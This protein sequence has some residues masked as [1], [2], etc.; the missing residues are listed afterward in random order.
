MVCVL[1]SVAAI[2]LMVDPSPTNYVHEEIYL[3]DNK[4]HIRYSVN[5]P[6]TTFILP[7]ELSEVSGLSLGPQKNQLLAVQDEDGILYSINLN[8]GDII[9]RTRFAGKGDYEAVENAAGFQYI[10]KSNGNLYRYKDQSHNEKI[11][12]IPKDYVKVNLEGMAYDNK[13]E[14]LIFACKSCSKE[15]KK[16]L[17][18][19]F[20]SL[21]L[22]KVDKKAKLLFQVDL[23]MVQKFII[24]NRTDQDIR[25]FDNVYLRN[26][27]KFKFAPSAISIHPKSGD[28]YVLSSVGKVLMVLNSQGNIKQLISLDPEIHRQP[29]GICFDNSGVLYISNE[30]RKGFAKL[31]KFFPQ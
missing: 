5:A 31:H 30:G 27:D 1:I 26:T 2:L 6:D 4:K 10:L 29:E 14:R 11:N 8:S 28:I 7:L 24:D 21:P 12:M 17:S 22:E 23:N 16:G 3:K 9:D 15:D 19:S 20:F 25:R 18:R 13:N